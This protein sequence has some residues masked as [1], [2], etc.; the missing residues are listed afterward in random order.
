MYWSYMSNCLDDNFL[1]LLELLFQNNKTKYNFWLLYPP[2]LNSIT[3]FPL[4]QL[5]C[6]LKTLQR[7]YI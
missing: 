5:K 1:L 7:Q 3:S 2:L 4:T 6:L